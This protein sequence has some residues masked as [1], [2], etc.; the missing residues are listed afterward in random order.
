MLRVEG[1][2]AGVRGGE[3]HELELER[4]H[5]AGAVAAAQR[6]KELRLPV[7][8]PETIS[9][10]PVTTLALRTR[11]AAS[12]YGRPSQP[13]PPPGGS[14][15]R[16]PSATIRPGRRGRARPLPWRPRPRGR[17]GRRGRF[18]GRDRRPRRSRA[19]GAGGIASSSG[20]NATAPWPVAW[21]ATRKPAPA[22]KRT[23]GATSP[24]SAASTTAAGRW[25]TVRF[26]AWRAAS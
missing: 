7:L 15:R 21:G 6:P 11:S 14:P 16:R 24:M 23:T 20:G 10:V 3:R 5:D 8:V 4:G 18:A 1:Q 25:S 17:P 9:P 12:P 22:A 13:R 26:Q 2:A 19:T